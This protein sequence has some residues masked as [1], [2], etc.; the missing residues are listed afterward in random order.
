MKLEYKV[1]TVTI[2]QVP[3]TAKVGGK[4]REVLTDAMTVELVP[5][6]DGKVVTLQLHDAEE[7]EKLFK[8]GKKITLT[9]AG[10]N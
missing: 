5:V 9:L 6:E 10:A 2:D 8:K 3:V 4:D 7:A 1:H